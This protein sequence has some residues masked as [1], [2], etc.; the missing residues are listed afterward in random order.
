MTLA[1]TRLRISTPTEPIASGRGFYQLEEDAL[2]IQIGLF[3]PNY[4]FFSYLESESVHLELDRQA[5]LI[6]IEVTQPRRRWEVSDDLHFPGVAEMA[7]LRWLDF[8]ETIE[9]P[10]LL[11][12][13]SRTLLHLQFSTDSSTRN[14]Y[15]TRHVIAQI[16]SADHLA[17]IWINN[18]EDDLAGRGIA[19]FRKRCRREAVS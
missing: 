17:A 15:L 18:I 9:E 12:D 13:Y 11:T 14:F 1:A 6:F 10:R 2:Y 3:D 7:D 4:R 5:R 8:R 19:S 16:D